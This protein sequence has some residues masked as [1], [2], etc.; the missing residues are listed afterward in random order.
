MINLDTVAD[1]TY[2]WGCTFFLETPEGNFEWSDSDYPGG[3]NTITPFDGTLKDFLNKINI[4]YGR[5]KGQ[6]T[7]EAYCGEEVKILEEC[8]D[9]KGTGVYMGMPDFIG[10][11]TSAAGYIGTCSYCTACEG[12]GYV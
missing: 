9:C 11:D 5:C 10:D 8:P 7:I 12:K 2:C 4:Q 3:D 6:H 1:F